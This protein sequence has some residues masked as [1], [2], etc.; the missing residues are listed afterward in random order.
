MIDNSY[1]YNPD[2][3]CSSL[4][5]RYCFRTLS[6]LKFSWQLSPTQPFARCPPWQ[7]GGESPKSKSEKTC[8]LT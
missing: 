1:Y 7:D 8:E 5:L 3:K 2:P 6:W 4:L